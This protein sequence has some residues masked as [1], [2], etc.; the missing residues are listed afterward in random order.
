MLPAV[1]LVGGRVVRLHQ[2]RYDQATTYPVEPVELARRYA[3]AGA[4]WL[5]VVDLDAAR[6]GE[7]SRGARAA[8]C[9][10]SWMSPACGCSSAAGSAPR[11]R[12]PRRSS[13]A[14]PG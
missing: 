4:R 2:G 11:P 5:H 12:S 1:D 7:R 14:P 13:W 3:A 8:C 6:T 10:A 9:R